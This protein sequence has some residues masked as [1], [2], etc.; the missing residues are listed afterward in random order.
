MVRVPPTEIVVH[1]RLATY[2]G[3]VFALP[4][5]TNSGAGCYGTIRE[6]GSGIVQEHGEGFHETI[7]ILLIVVRLDRD[8]YECPVLPG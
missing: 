4:L 8:S 1:V 2:A 3:R 6:T 7:D 5:R